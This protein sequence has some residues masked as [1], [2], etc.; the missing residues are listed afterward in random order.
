MTLTVWVAHEELASISDAGW[1]SFE[2]SK[3]LLICQPCLVTQNHVCG[4]KRI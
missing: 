4:G 3:R 2:R 1:L